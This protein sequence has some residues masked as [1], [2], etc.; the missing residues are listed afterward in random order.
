MLIASTSEVYGD[1]G[2]HLQV[3]RYFGSA[4]P[5][6]PRGCYDEAERFQ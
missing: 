4:T 3:E 5:V 1:P 6:K 2:V